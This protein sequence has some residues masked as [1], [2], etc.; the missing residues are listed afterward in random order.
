MKL[1]KLELFVY[2]SMITQFK[3]ENKALYYKLNKV[4]GY[5]Q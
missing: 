1:S 4:E 5:F 3:Y 2:R